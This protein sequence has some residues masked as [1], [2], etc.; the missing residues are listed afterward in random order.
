MKA[1]LPRA[2]SFAS[3]VVAGVGG[4]G[5]LPAAGYGARTTVWGDGRL[6]VA[7]VATFCNDGGGVAI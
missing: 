5:A 2:V 4:A 7:K 6:N 3:L 1:A